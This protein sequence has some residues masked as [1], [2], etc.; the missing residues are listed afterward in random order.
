M[1]VVLVVEVDLVEGDQMVLLEDVEPSHVGHTVGGGQDVLGVDDGARAKDLVGKHYS[2]YGQT[3]VSHGLDWGRSGTLR[4]GSFLLL[5]SLL[6][7]SLPLLFSPGVCL[8]AHFSLHFPGLSVTDPGVVL[9]VLVA[10]QDQ[11]PAAGVVLPR[12]PLL[13]PH[14]PDGVPGVL[15]PLLLLLLTGPHLI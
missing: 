8:R 4:V 3:G 12:P 5:L 7:V 1:G 14:H 11:G 2:H 13:L 10:H 15:L 9:V 6:L